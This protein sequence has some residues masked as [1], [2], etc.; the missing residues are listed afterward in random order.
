M[1]K[2]GFISLLVLCS[3]NI[4]AQSPV[5]DLV[6]TENSFAAYALAHG[7]K[8]A[9][10]QFADSNG[11]VFSN[12]KAVNAIETWTKRE[13]NNAV[14]KWYPV[15]AETAASGD[16]GYTT[17]PWTYQ[18]SPQDSAT[19]Y[20]YFITVWHRTKK[21]K[22]KF[23]LDMGISNDTSIVETGIKKI[24][25]STIFKGETED[26][27][28]KAEDNFIQ[29]YK[30]SG[31]DA[32]SMVLTDRSRLNRNGWP[33]AITTKERFSMLYE[34]PDSISYIINGSGIASSHDLGYVYGTLTVNGKTD[35]YLRIWR[36]ENTGWKIA[37]EVARW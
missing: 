18:A 15:L 35:N 3:A 31:T 4:F 1:Y 12:G 5:D 14:L 36:K 33:P 20:G 7:T 17:G 21:G 22:W 24:T 2:A 30:K 26:S 23:L 34:T 27:V 9:F 19:A 6:K 29:A 10:L 16:L 13:K 37:L 25:D 28:S 8:E 11:L 32:Y